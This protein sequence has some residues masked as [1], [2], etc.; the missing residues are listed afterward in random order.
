MRAIK[1]GLGY[2]ALVFALGF[3]LGIT[4]IS[5]VIPA[6]GVRWAELLELPTV[7]RRAALSAADK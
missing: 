5:F 6:P 1:T 4:R 2:F 7:F 3:A